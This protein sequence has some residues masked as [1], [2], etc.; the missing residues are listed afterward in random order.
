MNNLKIVFMGTPEFAVA[1]L[2]AI[3]EEGFNVLGVITVPDKPAG[4]GLQLK[5]SPVKEYALAQ[6]L[7]VLQPEKLK[8]PAFIEQLKS[9]KCDVQV[10]VAFRML[11]EIVWNMPPKG[12]I[13]LHASL[14]PQYRGAAPVNHAIINGEKETGVTTFFLDKEI[15]TGKMIFAEKV[16]IG[17]NEDAGSLHNR[18]MDIGAKLIIKSLKAIE[19]GE[20]VPIEQSTVI[21]DI[22]ILKKA[23]KIFKEDCEIDWNNATQLIFNLIRGLSPY[24]AS[25]TT[26]QGPD[27]KTFQLKIFKAT[28]VESENSGNA[29][30]IRTDGK[31]YLLVAS[32]D[33]F[34]SLD[35]VQIEGKK[36]MGIEEFLRGF[37]INNEWKTLKKSGSSA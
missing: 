36:K 27:G 33:G 35:I 23:P 31:K 7:K 32:V 6:N 10:V 29:G 9:L 25:F 13:N 14:L 26:L 24:P 8:D 30:E 2:K 34:L 3:V 1:S 28:V 5:Q 19:M 21:S 20:I 4:R 22:S 37:Y 18:L 12:T 15:D 11:P 16:S 17:E